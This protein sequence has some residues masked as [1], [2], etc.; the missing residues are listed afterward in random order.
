MRNHKGVRKNGM[1]RGLPAV[2]ALLI[3]IWAAGTAA[4]E[5]E[6]RILFENGQVYMDGEI[7]PEYD[8][9]W[10]ADPSAARGGTGNVPAEYFTGTEPSGED[11][12]YVAHDITYFPEVEADRFQLVQYKKDMAWGWYYPDEELSG[13]IWGLLPVS[14]PRVPAWQMHSREEA[15]GNPVLHVTVP[16]TY[17]LSGSWQGQI[18]VDVGNKNEIYADSTARVVLILDGL[19]LTCTVAPAVIFNSVYEA[20]SGWAE[21]E[22]PT[23]EVDLR[24]AGATIV[25]AD[26]SVN[27]ISGT[28]VARMLKAAY[29]GETEEEQAAED[30]AGIKEQP[31]MRK[32]DGA[33]HSEQSLLITGGEKGNGS[34]SVMAGWEGIASEL[35]LTIDGGNLH[36]TSR[37]D[38]I[39]AGEDDVSVITINGG[40]VQVDAGNGAYGDGIDSNGYLVINGGN[41]TVVSKSQSDSG[42]DS[43]RGTIINGGWVY[44]GGSTKDIAE[45]GSGQC[46]INLRFTS[47]VSTEEAVVFT[48]GNGETVFAYDPETAGF[49]AREYFGAVVSAPA[50]TLGETYRLY[51]GGDA[52]NGRRQVFRSRDSA[53]FG[54]ATLA[55]RFC[56]TLNDLEGFPGS[57][58]AL[59][60]TP[61]LAEKILEICSR[62]GIDTGLT[63]DMLIRVKG[64]IG[65][66]ELL[67]GTSV[68]AEKPRTY[69]DITGE[70]NEPSGDFIPDGP[71]SFFVDIEDSLI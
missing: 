24:D 30:A 28:N 64:K 50:F 70:K 51:L 59:E 29:K 22:T 47:A 5:A 16:G 15:S 42:L 21:R 19:E 7:V 36:I 13:Y 69:Y 52:E 55:I 8:Y 37:D 58:L 48:D 2:L 17:R 65:L 71:V 3:L 34:L 9:T 33:I 41:V 63:V 20:D 45:S 62:E 32:W 25:I 18:L 39:N 49:G 4:A 6:H 60:L 61:E 31:K 27:R 40:T 11:A 10:H 46:V 26:D 54:T 23:A 14:G 67:A 66:T 53:A 56:G 44:S 1:I 57:G 35:H 38:G 12:V 43:D 68:G